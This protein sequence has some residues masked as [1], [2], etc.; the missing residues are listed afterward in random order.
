MEKVTLYKR[1]AKSNIIKWEIEQV[2]ENTIKVTHGIIDKSPIVDY[3]NVTKKK[4]NELESR[5]NAKRKEGY[6]ALEDLYDNA[7]TNIDENRNLYKFLDTYLPKYNT[8]DEGFVLPMLAKT[9]EDNK[10]FEKYGTMLGQYKINGLRCIV[11]AERSDDMFDPIKLTYTSREGTRWELPHMDC[12]ILSHLSQELI[13]RMVE[14]G[15]CLDGE[16]YIPGYSV[17]QINSF[18]KNSALP[19]H[20]ELQYWCYDIAMEDSVAQSRQDYL[21]RN[22]Y[23]F[24]QVNFYTENSHK[25]NYERFVILPNF[26]IDDIWQAYKYRDQFIR[27]GFEGLILRNPNAEYAFGKRNQSMF[28]F[29]KIQDG[30]FKIVNIEEDKRGLPIYTLQNDINDELFQCTLNNTQ[31]IQKIHLQAKDNII[32]KMAT[33]EYRERSGVKEVPFHAKIVFIHV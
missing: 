20:K 10:P 3:I 17:N 18:V 25:D 27:L 28:K 2:S 8:T 12:Y 1:N 11:G 21:V 26:V 30:L 22:T 15:V 32:G 14:E 31:K 29:K 13:E 4:V 6:K 23:P 33:V 7:P 16:L 19:Q 5:V 24:I 9:L